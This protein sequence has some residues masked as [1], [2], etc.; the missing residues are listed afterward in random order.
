[1][2]TVLT[3]C[4]RKI[5]EVLI[6]LSFL[7]LCYAAV[8]QQIARSEIVSFNKDSS[9]APTGYDASLFSSLR[10]RNLGPD[11]GGRSI[12][13]A[14]VVKRPLEYYFGAVGGGLWQTIEAARPGIPLLMGRFTAHQSARS[15]FRNRILTSFTSAWA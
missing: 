8:A 10:W 11:R 12:A 1:M 6:V 2:R 5:V 14:G 4:P 13:S 9:Q 7:S 15:R 3:S